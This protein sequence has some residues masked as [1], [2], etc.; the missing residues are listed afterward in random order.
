[1]TTILSALSVTTQQLTPA[2]RRVLDAIIEKL[3][4]LERGG[5]ISR[6]KGSPRALAVLRHPT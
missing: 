3:A 5:W 1:M 6:R 2:Q 4:A